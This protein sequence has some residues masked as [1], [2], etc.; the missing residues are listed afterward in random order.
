MIIPTLLL[1]FGILCLIG[2]G[3]CFYKAG[4][5]TAFDQDDSPLI[6]GVVTLIFGASL[7]AAGGYYIRDASDLRYPP[8]AQSAPVST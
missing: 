8:A 6:L 1:I 7:I 3:V 2:S 5:Q 4:T